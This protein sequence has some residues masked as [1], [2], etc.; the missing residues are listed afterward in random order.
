MDDAEEVGSSG[1]NLTCRWIWNLPPCPG[2]Q[3]LCTCQ[4]S[5]QRRG[6][7]GEKHSPLTTGHE[8]RDWLSKAAEWVRCNH[9]HQSNTVHLELW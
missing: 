4:W 3:N 5:T 9:N 7:R 8:P 2:S 1:R 6:R